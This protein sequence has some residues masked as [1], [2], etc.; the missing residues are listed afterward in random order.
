MLIGKYTIVN[1]N[2]IIIT[3]LPPKT[4]LEPYIKFL[5]GLD[6]VNRIYDESSIKNTHIKV[7]FTDG[8]LDTLKSSYNQVNKHLD[9]IESNLKLYTKLSHHIN[10]YTAKNTV[11]EY[12]NY[13]DI[14]YDW[15]IVRKECYIKR[16]ERESIILKYKIILL[17]N[18]IR[19][20]ENHETYDLSKKKDDIINKIL[21]SNNYIML[22][23]SIIESPGIIQNNEIENKIINENASY[24]YL[25]NLSYRL[26]NESAYDRFKLKLEEYKSLYEFYSQDNIYKKIWIDEINSLSKI[27]KKGFTEGFYRE[28]E[29]VF[30]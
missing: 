9:Y 12:D 2:E 23:K 24:N 13:L 16:I 27:L 20:I 29:S 6:Y 4:W 10:L 21:T 17:E 14:I 7:V 19:F 5:E 15:Y 26:M 8:A 25:L 30:K 3:D 18:T 22:N 11:T 1:N 28:N